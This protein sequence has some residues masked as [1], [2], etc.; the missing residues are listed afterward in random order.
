MPFVTRK[1]NFVHTHRRE[2]IK[3]WD[4]NNLVHEPTSNL[5]LWVCWLNSLNTYCRILAV[6]LCADPFHLGRT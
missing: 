2:V 5:F 3:G 6:K 4:E 1:I